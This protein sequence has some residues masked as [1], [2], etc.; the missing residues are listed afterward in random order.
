[1]AEGGHQNNVVPDVEVGVAG[2]QAFVIA[3]KAG[4]G[5][6]D[7]PKFISI[8]VQGGAKDLVVLLEYPVIFISY[9]LLV[10]A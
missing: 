9:V 4:H 3:H 2:G 7:H 6:L 1:M 5:E 10:C 8:L